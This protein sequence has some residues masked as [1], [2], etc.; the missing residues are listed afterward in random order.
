MRYV[1]LAQMGPTQMQEA[2]EAWREVVAGVSWV[3]GTDKAPAD[4]FA[5]L[6]ERLTPAIWMASLD[7][8]FSGAA[9]GRDM[10]RQRRKWFKRT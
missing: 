3:V 1:V 2:W 10:E 8:T 4:H 7:A 6:G 5:D 9:A